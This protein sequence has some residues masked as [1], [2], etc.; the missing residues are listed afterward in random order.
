[1]SHASSVVRFPMLTS[2]PPQS[3]SAANVAPQDIRHPSATSP[4]PHTEPRAHALTRKSYV[5]NQNN[6]C[7]KPA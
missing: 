4:L 3:S 6:I 5:A 2:S 7:P 1:M